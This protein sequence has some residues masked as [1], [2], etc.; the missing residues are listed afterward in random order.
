MVMIGDWSMNVT[1]AC[2]FS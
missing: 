2:A 1:W